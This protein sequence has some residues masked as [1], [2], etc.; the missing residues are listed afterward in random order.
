MQGIKRNSQC[1]CGSG[2]KYKKC[3][4]F[5]EREQEL[6]RRFT[7]R[8]LSAAREAKKERTSKVNEHK[9]EDSS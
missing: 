3:C 6:I 7:A 9:N 1:P 8:V 4:R 5:S 2:K